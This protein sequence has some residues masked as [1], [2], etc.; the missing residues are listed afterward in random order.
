MVDSISNPVEDST[1]EENQSSTI[2]TSGPKASDDPRYKKFFKMIQ[3]GV[4]PQAVKLKML[5]EGVD[6]SILE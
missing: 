4:P 2:N 6:A 5:S 1:R 3:F